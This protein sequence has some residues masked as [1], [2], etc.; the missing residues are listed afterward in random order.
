MVACGTGV[1]LRPEQPHPRMAGRL[2]HCGGR[3]AVLALGEATT[4]NAGLGQERMC[5]LWAR[6][7]AGLER[8]GALGPIL[9]GGLV[10]Q[11]GF[12]RGKAGGGFWILRVQGGD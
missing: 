4:P 6:C 8:T 11:T 1:V 9:D 12:P 2:V 7:V 5:V 3:R 10:G